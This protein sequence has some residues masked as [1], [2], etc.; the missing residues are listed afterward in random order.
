MAKTFKELFNKYLP[1]AEH[2]AILDGAEILRSRVDKEKRMIEVT[3]A[4]SKIIRKSKLYEIENAVCE[5]YKIQFCKILPK[6]PA[7]LFD[8]DYIPEV[9]LETERVAVAI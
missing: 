1:T 2:N 6:Y 5:A 9:L 8:Y 4:F 7:D 3:V